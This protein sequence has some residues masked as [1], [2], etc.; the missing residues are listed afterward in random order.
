MTERALPFALPAALPPAL[1]RVL[2]YW[3]GLKR[4]NNDMP[5][6]DDCDLGDLPDL[7]PTMMLIDVFA[8][9]ERFR[10]TQVG[11]GFG[12]AP[13]DQIVGKFVDEIAP[14]GP[15]EFIR[16]QLS[17]TIE[18]EAPTC[19]RHD[20]ESG[21]AGYS[22]LLLPMWGEGRIGMILGVIEWD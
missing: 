6:W 4:G 14:E 20:A 1:D 13:R 10:L 21:D 8:A 17:A 15:F 11:D 7:A 22:R 12:A 19:Y 18:S 9:P 16:S 2:A 3:R 5:F